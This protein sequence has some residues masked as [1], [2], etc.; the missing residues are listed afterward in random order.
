[1]RV[2]LE[3]E[4]HCRGCERTIQNELARLEGVLNI[5]AEYAEEKVEIEFNEK[6][7]NLDKIIEKMGEMGYEAKRINKNNE[8]YVKQKRN[9]LSDIVNRF[10][11]R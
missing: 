2:V 7:I 9:I 6:I 11:K 3:T 1:M 8:Q 5:K 4:M 10:T